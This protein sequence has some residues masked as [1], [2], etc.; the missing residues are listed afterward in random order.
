MT[1]FELDGAAAL[2]QYAPAAAAAFRRVQEV[3][4]SGLYDEVLE[5]PGVA[6]FAD[7]FRV[8]VSQVDERLRSAFADAT[9]KRQFDVAQMV[10]VA[11]MAPRLTAALDAVFGPS[12]W[13]E[14][15]R[16]VPVADV[17]ALI[18]SFLASVALLDRLDPT[19][20]E[21]VRLR[22]ARQHA[23]RLCASRRSVA[24]I[25]AGAGDADFEAVDHHETSDLSP[26]AKAALALTDAI[27]WTP[28][29]IPES[30]VADVRRELTPEQAVE[31][32]LDVVRNAANKIAVA[33]G[34]D[35][36]T[37]TDGVELFVTEPDGTLTVV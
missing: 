16:R 5:S 3:R 6:A 13:A 20:T 19:T 12:T 14:V 10:W 7:Q 1:S 2:E 15:P 36:P 30:V 24:A 37:I 4:P 29:A 23:C 35:A 33:L 26:A 31:V 32:V 11:D 25:E 27:I 22:G 18:E 21:L 28:L 17:W 34:S 9:G 8:D